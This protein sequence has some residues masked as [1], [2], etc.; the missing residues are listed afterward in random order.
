MSLLLAVCEVERVMPLRQVDALCF[1][2]SGGVQGVYI[3]VECKW[4]LKGQ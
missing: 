3:E 4:F 2:G 1:C